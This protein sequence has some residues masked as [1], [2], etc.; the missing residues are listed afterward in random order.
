MYIYYDIIYYNIEDTVA[1]TPA[2]IL[3]TFIYIILCNMHQYN[4]VVGIIF[5]L[6]VTA[7]NTPT[8]NIYTQQQSPAYQ[9]NAQHS[10]SQ[11]QYSPQPQQQYAPQNQQSQYYQAPSQSQPAHCEGRRQE[12]TGLSK[13]IPV[14]PGVTASPAASPYRQGPLSPSAQP[15][16]QQQN[17]WAPVPAPTSPQVVLV[18]VY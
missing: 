17:R 4:S 7:R 2:Y 13:L 1:N 14:G 10:P 11:Q 5:N 15:Y 6:H 3:F 18:N 12:A 16:R 9:N 8:S